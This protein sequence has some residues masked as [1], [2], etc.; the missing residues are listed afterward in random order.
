MAFAPTPL[1]LVEPSAPEPRDSAQLSDAELFDRYSAYVARIGMRLLGR[2]MD[3]D[4]LVQEV[5]FAAFKQRD[6][7]RDPAAAKSW[8][9]VV[10]VRA[11]R[12][13]L[14]RRRVRQFIGLDTPTPPFELQDHG[15]SA[16]KRSLLSRVYE[17]LDHM[18]V[19]DRLAWTLRHIE[20]EKLEQVAERCGCSL[21]TAKR[22]IA[23]A[24]TRL[25][26]ELHGG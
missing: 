7:L 5:F 15:L 3:V 13:E 2:N 12:R 20:G 23:A 6:Q 24:H 21:A 4:D 19:D 25:Q 26:T 17:V 10:A 16:D 18:D 9:S 22:R 1:R 11:A 14:R 8:L